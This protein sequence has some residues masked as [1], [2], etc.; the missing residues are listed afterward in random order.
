MYGITY[1]LRD[2]CTYLQ[3]ILLRQVEQISRR[4]AKAGAFAYTPP[5]AEAA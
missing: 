4:P 5:P 1:S 3:Q 2:G